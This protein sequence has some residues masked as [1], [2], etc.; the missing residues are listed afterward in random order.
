[1][2]IVTPAVVASFL[3][4][5][6]RCAGFLQAA[7]L[8][9]D[10][11]VPRRLRVAA[12]ALI[13]IALVPVRPVMTLEAV[14]MVLPCELL[15][16]LAAGFAGKLVL[17]GAEVGGQLIGFELEL[18]FA[19]MFDPSL[20]EQA[21]P[22]RRM[23]ISLASL[24]FLLVGGL[25]ESVRVLGRAS[26]DGRSLTHAIR[27]LILQ[28]GDM[29]VYGLRMLA[30]VLVAAITANFAGALASRAAPALNVFSVMLALV[31][32]I[33]GVALI[34]TAPAFVRELTNLGRHVTTATA[35]AVLR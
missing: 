21:L 32:V 30:P 28:S 29:F 35:N 22:T 15:L 31:L 16:G 8:T 19:E 4:L 20:G 34:A 10:T 33:G 2:P 11:V 26:V 25:E 17:A 6:A 3:C 24:A 1:M 27:S 14:P 9:S 7:P 13:A 5:F 12:A 23:A 18:G